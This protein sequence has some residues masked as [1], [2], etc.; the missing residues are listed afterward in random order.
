MKE[1]EGIDAKTYAGRA[2]KAAKTKVRGILG[3]DLLI[4]TLLDFVSFMSLNNKF[5]AA[6]VFITEDNKEEKYI[7]IIESN[8]ETLI[9]DLSRYIT[10]MDDIK[11]IQQRKDEYTRIIESLKILRDYDDINAVNNVI[12]EYLRR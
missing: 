9:D 1:I 8:D 10:L 11:V 7:E 5:A 3:D 12:E 6:G 4:F 2:A